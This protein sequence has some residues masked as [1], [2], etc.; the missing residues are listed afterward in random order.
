[1]FFKYADFLIFAPFLLKTEQNKLFYEVF[2]AF[3]SEIE[4]KL[5]FNVLL[6]A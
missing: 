1:M 6:K 2:V 3:L 5:I 4:V